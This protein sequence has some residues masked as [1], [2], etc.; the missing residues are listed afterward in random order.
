MMPGRADARDIEPK[1][2]SIDEVE[3]ELV[4]STFRVSNIIIKYTSKIP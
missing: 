1:N 3:L 2:M 4:I